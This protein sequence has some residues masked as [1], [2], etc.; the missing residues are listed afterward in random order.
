MIY[1]FIGIGGIG[2][3]ALAEV[4]HGYG[5]TVQ[6]SDM[7]NNASVKRLKAKGIKVFIGHDAKNLPDQGDVIISTAIPKDNIEVNTARS[8]SMNVIHRSDILAKILNDYA[9]KSVAISGTHGKTTTTALTYILMEACGLET[10]VING[11]V[12]KSIGTNAKTSEEWMVVEADESDGSFTKLRPTIAVVTS[13]DPEHMEHYG[14]MDQVRASYKEFVSHIPS[15]GFNVLSSEDGDVRCLAGY[16]EDK[17]FFYGFSKLADVRAVNIR[18]ENYTTL[19]DLEAFGKSY[20]NVILNMPG[21][22]NVQNALAAILIC[23]KLGGKVE[24]MRMPLAN[25]AGVGR[26]F[27]KLGMLENMTV[28]DDYG[29]HPVEIEATLKAA[30]DVF[31]G[32][33]LAVVQPHRYSRLENLMLGFAQSVKH[34]DAILVTPVYSAGEEPIDGV[35]SAAL[36]NVIKET[37]KAVLTIDSESELKDRIIEAQKGWGGDQNAVICLGA[38]SISQWAHNLCGDEA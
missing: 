33:I 7:S 20:S 11:G 24:D 5:E 8:R 1:H 17:S 2:M 19:F 34:A 25:F 4:L 16:Q 38:G 10:G 21:K 36:A 3:S 18:Q 29:H 35:S 32:K 22:H 26:R 27:N 6:G 15:G 23:L 12:I 28:I 13:I 14:G 30:K 37:G 31:K 9:E